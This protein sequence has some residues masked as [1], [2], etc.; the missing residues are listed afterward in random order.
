MRGEHLVCSVCQC[1]H[2]SSAITPECDGAAIC[3]QSQ[4]LRTS[5]RKHDAR[6]EAIGRRHAHALHACT[7]ITAQTKSDTRA[8]TLNKCT[9]SHG[10]ACAHTSMCAHNS[11]SG[12][13][14]R[15]MRLQ[16]SQI[17][18]AGDGLRTHGPSTPTESEDTPACARRKVSRALPRLA[19]HARRDAQQRVDR[20]KKEELCRAGQR[21]QLFFYRARGVRRG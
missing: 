17:S 8:P 10:C 1:M 12:R 18:R 11:D 21:R 14:L 9:T 3:N 20:S 15:S 16:L 13:A 4:A 6:M 5:T 7:C 19:V 2:Q